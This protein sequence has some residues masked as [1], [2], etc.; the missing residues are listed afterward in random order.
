[1]Q[2][3]YKLAPMQTLAVNIRKLI[4]DEVKDDSG[5]LLN[6]ARSTGWTSTRPGAAGDCL[7]PTDRLLK[8]ETSVVGIRGYFAESVSINSFSF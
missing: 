4:D 5:N 6:G 8:H 3:T 1:M 2:K 7:R